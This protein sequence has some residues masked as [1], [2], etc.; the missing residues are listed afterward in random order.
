MTPNAKKDSPRKTPSKQQKPSL[1]DKSIQEVKESTPY[2]N[3]TV[4][5]RVSEGK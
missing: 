1:L 5:E 4:I 2:S 3:N